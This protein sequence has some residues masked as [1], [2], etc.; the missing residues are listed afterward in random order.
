MLAAR[1]PAEAHS[2]TRN[3]SSFSHLGLLRFPEKSAKKHKTVLA[4]IL[5]PIKA[6]NAVLDVDET[7]ATRRVHKCAQL[8]GC[9]VVTRRK[10]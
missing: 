1:A 2:Q 7:L 5:L 9:A 3:A 4:V 10:L 8:V 6:P